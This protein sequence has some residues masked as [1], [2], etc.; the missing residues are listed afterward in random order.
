M[1]EN[2]QIRELLTDCKES[3]EWIVNREEWETLQNGSSAEDLINDIE[4]ILRSGV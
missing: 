4:K 1:K 2:K 3:L